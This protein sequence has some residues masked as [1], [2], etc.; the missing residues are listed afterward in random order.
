MSIL[1]DLNEVREYTNSITID[2]DNDSFYGRSLY[3]DPS[4]T[5]ERPDIFGASQGLLSQ[6]KKENKLGSDNSKKSGKSS[7]KKM[8]KQ[9]W[10][11]AEAKVQDERTE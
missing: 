10:S 6:M 8:E 5:M 3:H 7:R 1:M 11:E 2:Q 9:K 4:E